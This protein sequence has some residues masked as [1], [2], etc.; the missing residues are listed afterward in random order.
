MRILALDLS[1]SRTGWATSD[2][3]GVFVPP[4]GWVGMVRL[5]WIRNDVI[6]AASK[7]DLVVL[8]GYSYASKGRA[9]ISIAELGGV[10]RFALFLANIPFVAIPPSVLKK[11]AT[12]HGNAPKA[13]VLVA[14]VKRLGYEGSDDNVADA[15]WLLQLA[16][17][18]YGI[19]SSPVPKAQRDVA[20]KIV[21]PIVNRRE[22]A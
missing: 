10:I 5:G 14:A 11:Y 8:E 1:L 19:G 2:G 13:E 18:G 4:K 16:L 21:W 7:T 12:G 17:D 20:A 15:L 3:S 22:A 6:A 9:I